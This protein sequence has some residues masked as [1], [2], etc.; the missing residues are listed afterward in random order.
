[1]KLLCAEYN[2]KGEQAY[3][4]VGDNALLRN[5]EDFYIPDFTEKVSC[6]PQIVLRVCK[7]GKGVGER[8][9]ERYYE[10][11]GVGI[12]FYADDLENSLLNK[13]L[14][15]AMASSFDSSAA[16][17][18]LTRRMGSIENWSYT[19]RVNDKVCHERRVE[20]L[21]CPPERLIAGMSHY[22]ML[23]IGDFIYCGDTS[24]III[25]VGDRLRLSLNDMELLNFGIK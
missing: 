16:I 7:M 6:V 24:H 18:S 23:K 4:V 19:L 12:R 17:S 21:P 25:H 15:P 20:N 11:V 22:Y 9:A 14:S 13:R 3:S 8:F 1:M 2:E 5:N 10:E